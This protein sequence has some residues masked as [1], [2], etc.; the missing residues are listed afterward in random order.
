[1]AIEHGQAT[2]R[3]PASEPPRHVHLSVA[4]AHRPRLLLRS[5]R[6]RV[7]ASWW[8]APSVLSSERAISLAHWPPF[9]RPHSSTLFSQDNPGRP[10]F[11]MRAP[12]NH[13]LNQKV[14]RR[15]VEPAA[16]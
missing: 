13:K 11:A 10:I 12:P 6:V 4:A 15:S 7:F 2:L 14:L 1:M 16:N 3:V 5:A 8:I 9:H